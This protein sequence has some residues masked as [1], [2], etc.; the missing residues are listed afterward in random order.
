MVYFFFT[1]VGIRYYA[2]LPI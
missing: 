2:L 1:I